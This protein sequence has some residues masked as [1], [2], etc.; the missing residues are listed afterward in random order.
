MLADRISI[1][2][3][4]LIT[5]DMY[6]IFSINCSFYNRI[7]TTN[8]SVVLWWLGFC[9]CASSVAICD[10]LLRL[11]LDVWLI[12]DTVTPTLVD[13]VTSRRV[14]Y[15]RR[16]MSWAPGLPK[17]TLSTGVAYIK[18]NNTT[19]LKYHPLPPHKEKIKK[20]RLKWALIF[21]I[22]LLLLYHQSYYRLQVHL[23]HLLMACRR[24][25]QWFFSY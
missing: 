13:I 14:P 12:T 22:Y 16:R 7:A 23:C 1:I 5:M 15:R 11:T 2:P 3:C 24:S 9:V 25:I 10:N 20:S 6:C 4:L 19:S 21:F 17:M 18:T 8:L